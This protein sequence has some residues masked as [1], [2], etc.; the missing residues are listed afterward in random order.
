MNTNMHLAH[1][2]RYHWESPDLIVVTGEAG[3]IWKGY[4]SYCN[5]YGIPTSDQ[6]RSNWFTKMFLDF[7]KRA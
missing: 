1:Y 2:F 5:R 3:E 6:E 7:S 4:D